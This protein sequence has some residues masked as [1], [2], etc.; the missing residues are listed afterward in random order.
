MRTPAGSTDSTSSVVSVSNWKQFDTLVGI[1]YLPT[2]KQD[3]R[4]ITQK[5][6]QEMGKTF[7]AGLIF[8]KVR[9]GKQDLAGMFTFRNE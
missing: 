1:T 8:N 2:R 5:G 6:R 7:E 3:A 4:R 9:I